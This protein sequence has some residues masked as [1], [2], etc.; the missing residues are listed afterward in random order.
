MTSIIKKAVLATAGLLLL[1]GSPAFAARHD[2]HRETLQEELMVPTIGHQLPL[3]SSRSDNSS[4]YIGLWVEGY[5]RSSSKEL[6]P[7]ELIK[8]HLERQR[9]LMR[10][11]HTHPS[12]PKIAY[13]T[14]A[15]M[16]AV[17]PP[18]SATG[19]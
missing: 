6:P 7:N 4:P 16:S 11:L 13:R 8:R 12:V 3:S 18:I 5:P 19:V 1:A 2:A 9:A 14:A 10:S 17:A 15:S